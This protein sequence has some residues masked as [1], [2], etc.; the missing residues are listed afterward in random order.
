MVYSVDKYDANHIR[1]YATKNF[2]PEVFAKNIENNYRKCL[3]SS[4]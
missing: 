1:E 2:S 3:E 4:P